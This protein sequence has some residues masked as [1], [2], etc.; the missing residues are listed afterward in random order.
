MIC[1]FFLFLEPPANDSLTLGDSDSGITDVFDAPSKSFCSD[2]VST[3]VTGSEVGSLF[4]SPVIVSDLIPNGTN[5]KSFGA[6]LNTQSA[7]VGRLRGVNLETDYEAA[8]QRTGIIASQS[9][10]FKQIQGAT[11]NIALYY[12]ANA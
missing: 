4:G 12:A 7:L 1:V 10:G 3:E 9:L 2:L 11:S 8:N 5:L 6:I